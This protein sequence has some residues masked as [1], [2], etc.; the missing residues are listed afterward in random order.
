[1]ENDPK[2]IVRKVNIEHLMEAL[3]ELYHVGVEHVDL[4]SDTDNAVILRFSKDY[5][6]EEHKDNFE[7]I[8]VQN[9]ESQIN[10]K[11]SDDDLN[12]IV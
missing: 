12:N 8:V 6:H 4:C 3:Q 11:L 5:M 10:I 7:N 2:L 9:P 1:M